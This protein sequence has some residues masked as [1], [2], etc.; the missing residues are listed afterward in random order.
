MNLEGY[1]PDASC[2]AD[3]GLFGLPHG[4]DAAK[5]VVIPVPWEATTSYRRGT[6]AAPGALVEASHQVDLFD[7]ELG[8]AWRDGFA[9]RE[10]RPELAGLNDEACAA[11][12][13]VIEAGG[14]GDGEL[15]ALAERVNALSESMNAIVREE[16]AAVFDRGGIPA[17]Y[18]GDHS[19]PFGA[20]REAVRR[21]PDLGVL[22]VDA[23]L[24]LRVA[25]QGFQ[26]SH[27]S[28]MGNV[29]DRAGLR[30]ALVQVGVRDFGRAEWQRAQDD[31]RVMAYPWP[32]LGSALAGGRSWDSLARPMIDL[33]PEQVW[34]SFDIDGLDPAL[35]PA[36]GTPVPGGLSWDHT[37]ALLR[38]LRESGRTVVGFDLVEVGDAEWDA[39]IG[40]RLLYRMGGTAIL[41]QR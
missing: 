7:L 13:P 17:I 18:G 33:L 11:A 32:V 25:Y 29:L 12:L 1:D 3:D 9:M 5:V 19:V 41:S 21:Y 20:I 31:P 2:T 10:V 26:W 35:C 4:P 15:A 34:I 39:I 16:T 23:H 6:A 28:I 22:H 8:D 37:M 24:D 36:T 40:A 38:M 14:A 30:G 27:A